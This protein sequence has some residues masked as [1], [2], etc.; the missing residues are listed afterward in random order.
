MN[1]WIKNEQNPA[2]ALRFLVVESS[3]GARIL[4]RLHLLELKHLVDMAWDDESAIDLAFMSAYDF[5][6]VDKNLNCY[7]LIDR[8][9]K[10]S[11]FNEQT[12]II[13]LTSNP[14]EDETSQGSTIYFKKP[15]SKNDALQLLD[16]VQ[17]LK[18]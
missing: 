11:V 6:L 16:F 9:Q 8:I 12:P 1:N 2:H 10:N 14:N 5:I 4:M 7:E 15:I 17:T 18:K 3:L 13:I